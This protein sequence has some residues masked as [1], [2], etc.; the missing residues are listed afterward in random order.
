MKLADSCSCKG[1]YYPREPANLALAVSVAASPALSALER[2]TDLKKS[3]VNALAAAR[4]A[5]NHATAKL[6]ALG[7]VL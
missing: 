5:L 7:R 2:R 6:D 1:G 4:D 3:Q